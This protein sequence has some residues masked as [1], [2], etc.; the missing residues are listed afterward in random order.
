MVKFFSIVTLVFS[1]I[2][3]KEQTKKQ[4]STTEITQTN[5]VQTA[6]DIESSL[7]QT[8]SLEILYYNNP[9]GDPERYTRFFTYTATNDS[10]A[11]KTLIENIQQPITATALK[12]CR[13]EGK[14]YC[15]NK[16]EILS[17]LYF[18]TRG[19]SCSYLYFIK[20]GSMFYVDINNKTKQ[21]LSSFKKMA[22]KPISQ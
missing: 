2:A 13:S 4:A 6:L 20:T 22:K 21:I 3:C 9:D 14:I 7:Q 10:T 5:A 16:S 18:S 11:I 1:I 15:R 17:T 8:D 12:S 19:D